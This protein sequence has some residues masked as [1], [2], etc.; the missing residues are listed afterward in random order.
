[1]TDID[2]HYEVLKTAH[3]ILQ[4][5]DADDYPEVPT[6]MPNSLQEA[7]LIVQMTDKTLEPFC[8]AL[9]DIEERRQLALGYLGEAA[10]QDERLV[11]ESI[12]DV[13][14]ILD[15]TKEV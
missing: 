1:M 5:I 11:Y 2:A 4:R 6:F 3:G 13:V 10:M 7:A 14:S 15:L 8:R 9:L 12:E